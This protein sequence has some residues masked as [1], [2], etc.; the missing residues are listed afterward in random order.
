MFTLW[1]AHNTSI[2]TGDVLF[3]SFWLYVLKSQ[4]I[5]KKETRKKLI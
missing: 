4:A 5:D 3:L 2:I 1:F